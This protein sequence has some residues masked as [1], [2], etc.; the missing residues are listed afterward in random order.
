MKNNIL[1]YKGYRAE[2]NFSADDMT[3]Y[4]KVLDVSDSII[5]EIE[6]AGEAQIE[7]VDTIE[8]YI[9]MC[10]ENGKQPCTPDRVDDKASV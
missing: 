10:A 2:I 1:K 8:D 4:G 3:L 5:F 6:R 7:F 9:C